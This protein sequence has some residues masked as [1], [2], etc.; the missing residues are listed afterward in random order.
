MS[1]SKKGLY[2]KYKFEE[3]RAYDSIMKE[4]IEMAKKIGESDSTVI[5][6]GEI[7]TGKEMVAQSMPNV[8]LRNNS[9]FTIIYLGIFLS[10]RFKSVQ[11]LSII[12]FTSF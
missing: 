12:Y 4:T 3:I 10:K 1:L 5:L 2:A 11:P 8:S 7:G 6:Y 9:P